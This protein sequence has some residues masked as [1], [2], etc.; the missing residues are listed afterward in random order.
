MR[1]CPT[2]ILQEPDGSA[3]GHWG[4]YSLRSAFQPIYTFD[5]SQL[6]LWSV[7]GLIRPFRNGAPKSPHA[8]FAAIPDVDRLHV[9]TLARDLH[10]RNAASSFGPSVT[11]FINFDP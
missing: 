7:E 2:R 11:L 10:I 8:F 3:V 4:P 6:K 9:E 5:R 1:S